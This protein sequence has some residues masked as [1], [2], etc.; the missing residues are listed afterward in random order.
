MIQNK[1][2]KSVFQVATIGFKSNKFDWLVKVIWGNATLLR[3]HTVK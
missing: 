1:T 2:I 3:T